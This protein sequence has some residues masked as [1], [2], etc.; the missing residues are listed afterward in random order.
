ML[1]LCFLHLFQNELNVQS[2][3][4]LLQARNRSATETM[5]RNEFAQAL[6]HSTILHHLSKRVCDLLRFVWRAKLFTFMCHRSKSTSK[7][8]RFMPEFNYIIRHRFIL[9]FKKGAYSRS[10][11]EK[12]LLI[13]KYFA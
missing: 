13:A 5:S 1:A 9:F 12:Q 3:D 6:F 10:A 8:K 7:E 4:P 2:K 11:M